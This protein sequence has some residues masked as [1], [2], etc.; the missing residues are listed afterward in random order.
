MT[1][2]RWVP[3]A[4]LGDVVLP[5]EPLPF[6]IIDGH[7][8]L[9]LARGHAV[10]DARQLQTL[11]ERGAC[12][13]L[14]EAAAARRAREG[15]AEPG[16]AI[17]RIRTWF[18][19]FERHV[20]QLDALLRALPVGTPIATSLAAFGRE[21]QALI[22]RQPDAALF[23]AVR[24]DDRRFALYGLT[25]ALHTA[26]VVL[27]TARLL[28]WP[29][30]RIR[31]VFMAALTMNA[32]IVELQARMAEQREPP[33]RRQIEQVRAHPATSAQWLRAGGVDDTAWLAAV[34]DHHERAGGSGYPRGLPAVGEEARLLRAADVYAAKIS[35]RVIRAAMLPQRAARELFQDEQGSPLAAALIKAVGVYPPGEFVHLKNG[36]TAVVV[37]RAGGGRAAQVTALFDAPGRPLLSASR[38]DTATPAYAITGALTE[39]E[40]SGL[41]RVLPEQVFGLL[42]AESAA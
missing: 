22:E 41:P 20:W 3:L 40:R 24:Q 19:R 38:R 37:H 42:E 32:A 33:T 1:P 18:D 29:A 13:E 16:P 21:H 30:G 12:V 4:E 31:S 26:T 6:R 34:E 7:G 27:L 9:L 36:E 5:G 15:V 23:V 35:P 2:A 8:R 28:D 10:Q 14:E 11:I 39:A 25:H 17:A